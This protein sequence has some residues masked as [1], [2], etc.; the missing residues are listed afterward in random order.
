MSFFLLG[1]FSAFSGTVYWGFTTD[2]NNN[3]KTRQTYS[4][5]FLFD[6]QPFENIPVFLNYNYNIGLVNKGGLYVHSSLTAL[7]ILKLVAPL[8]S[9]K[10]K[11]KVITYILSL[12]IPSGVTYNFINKQQFRLGIYCNPLG[13][14]YYNLPG[15]EEI[16]ASVI[17]LGIKSTKSIS[18][19]V[20][21]Y[22]SVGA[23]YNISVGSKKL[24]PAN[25]S[26]SFI[27][28]ARLGVAIF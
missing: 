20:A 5:G 27:P 22:M 23:N 16:S 26:N 9:V 11:I 7:G 25:Y 6:A 14:D 12:V 10:L 15:K 4:V 28:N 21:L 18:D 3:F 24:L 19:K 8:D 1:S 2:F 13:Y 17:E